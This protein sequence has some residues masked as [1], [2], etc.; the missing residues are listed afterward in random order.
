MNFRKRVSFAFLL[1]LCTIFVPSAF[2]AYDGIWKNS[3][4]TVNVYVQTYA[5]DS[6]LV[7]V[8]SDLSRYD[9]F[10]DGNYLDGFDADD[11]KGEG[12]HASVQ[13]T[14]ESEA[15]LT[16]TLFGV[17]ATHQ[18]TK[19]VGVPAQSANQGIWKTPNCSSV[20]MNYYVQTYD[21]GSALVIGT[22]DLVTYFVFL[23]PDMSDGIDTNEYSGLPYHL[24]MGF[25]TAGDGDTM[26]RCAEAP[27]E[28]SSVSS[29]AWCN[30]DI[31]PPVSEYTNSLGMTFNY[32]SPGSFL[33]GSPDTEFQ[34][35]EDEGPQHSVTLTQGF[36]M[37]T[38]EVTQ[39]QW[40]AL[41]GENPSFF[42][43]CGNDCPVER[44][45]WQDAQEFISLLNALGEGAYR[46]PTEAE[47]EYACRAGSTTAYSNGQILDDGCAD[48]NLDAIAWYCGT[49]ELTTHPV[50]Q[51]APNGWGLYDMHGNVWELCQD[52]YGAYS[53]DAAVDPTGA[54]TGSYRVRRGGALRDVTGSCR[55]ANRRENSETYKSLDVGFRVVRNA[56]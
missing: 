7:L 47:W 52:W 13:F 39:G 29:N 15:S 25:G 19:F 23:D 27:S 46:L 55:S 16:L 43:A 56:P 34:R 2:A 3:N 12:N 21:T 20:N 6:M 9:A 41:M 44:I 37:Q 11:L 48:L 31:K 36:Y 22:A 38:T 32:I 17:E 24:N 30:L 18:I 53:A 45:T 28:G 49:A 14:G 26:Q 42:S 51:K 4:L 35:E 54:E 50:A 8:T 33:M 1:A 40:A 5:N 10:I